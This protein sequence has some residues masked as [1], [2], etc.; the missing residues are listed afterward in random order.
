MFM[1]QYRLTIIING[2]T[3]NTCGLDRKIL[4]AMGRSTEDAQ[5]WTLYKKGPLWF[6]ERAM[7]TSDHGV[8]TDKSHE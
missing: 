7:M 1:T 2:K 5:Y 6:G 3:F 4:T 8:S